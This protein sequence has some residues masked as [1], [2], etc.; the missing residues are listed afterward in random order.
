VG[1]AIYTKAEREQM[2]INE[3][4]AVR[5]HAAPGVAIHDIAN[6]WPAMADDEWREFVAD[7]AANGLLDPIITWRGAIVD[8]KHRYKACTE[9]SVEP[10]FDRLPDEW[11]EWKV[12]VHCQ[13]KHRRRN[14]SATQKACVA[15]EVIEKYGQAAK[16]RISATTATSNQIRAGKE[17]ASAPGRDL[18]TGKAAAAAAKDFG[19][20]ERSV[21]RALAVKK[22]APEVYELAKDD[23]I[24][25]KVAER[26]AKEPDQVKRAAM[27][28]QLDTGARS[29]DAGDSWGTPPEWIDLARK[30]M[31]DI[32]LDPASNNEAQQVVN[33]KRFFTKDTNGLEQTWSGRVW[34]N[35]PYSQP[36]V[37]Q[38]AEKLVAS[39][40]SGEVTQ[41]CVL[42][43]NATDARFLQLMLARCSAALFPRGRIPFL[44]PGSGE[45]LTGTR[46]GQA[47]L[48]FGPN[49]DGFAEHA[50]ALG[51]VGVSHR[52]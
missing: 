17:P 44:I 19:S 40:E 27:I 48:Y 47:F 7:I 8:G 49:V 15:A 46:Q 24:P 29:D 35:P 11:D 41:A 25:L 9:T 51:W 38:F 16:E 31:G 23:K 37:T 28:G 14:L 12:A 10:R 32:D 50:K 36:L 42:V 21:E 2:A 26:I 20:S 45:S 18:D 52:G 6:L 33:A 1:K 4:H 22:N 3:S 43:N 34:M 13:S 39:I 5:K 30:T